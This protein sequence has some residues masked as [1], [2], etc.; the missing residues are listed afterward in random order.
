MGCLAAP[1]QRLLF[2]NASRMICIYD[3]ANRLTHGSAKWKVI[4]VGT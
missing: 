3:D 1:T 4:V 2:R